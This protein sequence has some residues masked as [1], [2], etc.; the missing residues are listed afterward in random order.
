MD[1]VQVDSATRLELDGLP[2]ENIVGLVVGEDDG[3]RVSLYAPDELQTA[4]APLGLPAAEA[5]PEVRDID[6]GTIEIVRL[7]SRVYERTNLATPDDEN[8]M[9]RVV[10]DR[11]AWQ[12]VHR[13][14]AETG[15]IRDEPRGASGRKVFMRI[16][17]RPRDL[18]AGQAPN[19]NVDV[20]IRQF[21]DMLEERAPSTA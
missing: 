5:P 7:L 9:R 19:A 13:A 8:I 21:W 10:Q 12:V 18:L 14:L 2:L 20:R 16:L 11:A 6:A 1:G 17:V 3:P 4:L 15:V